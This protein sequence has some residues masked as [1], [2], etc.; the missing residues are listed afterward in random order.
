VTASITIVKP[1]LLTTVQDLGRWGSQA[2]GVSVAGPMDPRSHRLANALAGNGPNAA[3]LEITIVGPEVEFEDDR[4]VAVVGALFEVFVNGKPVS[5]GGFSVSRRARL[6]FGRRHQGSR[7]YLAVSGGI[8]V[9]A[10]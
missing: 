1:G 9:P 3:T 10:P 2:Q 7:A 6:A 4:Q 5:G 8:A